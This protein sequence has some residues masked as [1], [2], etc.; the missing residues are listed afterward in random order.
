MNKEGGVTDFHIE[1]VL[2]SDP[3]VEGMK[4]IE[5]PRYVTFDPKQNLKFVLFCEDFKGKLDP[6]SAVPLKSAAILDYLK[7][8]L[9]LKQDDRPQILLYAFRFLDHAD[10]GV[11]SEALL[12]FAR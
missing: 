7:G 12:E 3:F 6:Y 8:V 1:Q 2:K 9:P 10:E 11:A 5:V 4:V